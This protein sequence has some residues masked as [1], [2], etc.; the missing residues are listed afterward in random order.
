[1]TP[2]KIESGTDL[3]TSAREADGIAH[4][5]AIE[6]QNVKE[7]FEQHLTESTSERQF[8][9]EPG[10][11]FYGGIGF[12]IVYITAQTERPRIVPKIVHYIEA[13]SKFGPSFSGES[14][15][16]LEFTVD[17][18]LR[19]GVPQRFATWLTFTNRY[20]DWQS[21]HITIEPLE[22]GDLDAPDLSQEPY[23]PTEA[24]AG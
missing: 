21:Q 18:P 7:A 5:A 17:T 22:D 23:E 19:D 4:K 6:I 11:A 12:D 3:Y 15:F 16:L 10:T 1:M 13:S 9:L 20:G 14:G 2:P 8:F 24:V